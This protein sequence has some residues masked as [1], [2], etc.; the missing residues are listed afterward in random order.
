MWNGTVA[1]GEVIFPVKLYAVAQDRRVRFR[2]VRLAD[3][4]RIVHRRFGSESGEEVPNERIRKAYEISDGNQVV[5]EDDEIA[6]ARGSNAKVIQI[7]HFVVADDIDPIYYDRP[8]LLGAQPGGEHAY[9]VLHAALAQTGKVGIGRF[10]LR[11][12]EQL[13]AMA[14][15]DASLRLYTM[16]FADEIIPSSELDV[17][18]LSREP[19]SRE[20]EMAERL[21]DTLAQPWE[22]ERHEDRH[23]DAIM[24]LIEQKASGAEV[25]A[26]AAPEPEPTPDLLAALEQSLKAGAPRKRGAKAGAAKRRTPAKPTKPKAGSSSRSTSRARTR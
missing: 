8:Y 7:E 23:R 16:R 17:P 21:V 22:P 11:T 18:K 10:T 6:T 3:G 14:P 1:F 13:V 12:R 2:E 20:L 5:L 4:C 24:A 25:Q 19:S 9:R 26:A 15:H